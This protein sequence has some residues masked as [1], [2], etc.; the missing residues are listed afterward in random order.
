MSDVRNSPLTGRSAQFSSDEVF[1]YNEKERLG[2]WAATEQV[3]I[4]GF[5]LDKSY[6]SRRL[7]L[8]VADTNRMIALARSKVWI[9]NRL[10]R[11]RILFMTED[12][13]RDYIDSKRDNLGNFQIVTPESLHEEAQALTF[14][15][16]AAHTLANIFRSEDEVGAGVDL[17]MLTLP[18]PGGYAHNIPDKTYPL[19]ILYGCQP[20]E[21]L[22]VLRYLID[23]GWIIEGDNASVVGATYYVTPAGY[24]YSDSV[25]RGESDEAKSAFLICRFNDCLDHIYGAVYSVA[26][27]GKELSCPIYRVKDVEH[28]D[29]IDDRIMAEI[30][31]AT[32]VIVD[33]T[34]ALQNFNV[35]MEAGYALAKGKPIIWTKQDDGT[36]INLPFDIHSQN[37]MSWKR[38]GDEY[39]DFAER[40]RARMKVAIDKA[41][42]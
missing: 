10:G 24:A 26:G 42:D 3:L 15:D 33:L 39:G 17:P 27:N 18:Y 12:G 40:L 6:Q 4:G 14:K 36:D 7:R 23:N 34:D 38:D 11:K 41:S 28:V 22:I 37:L 8:N 35:A 13:L 32:I 25:L 31:A 30:N 9:N 2:V 5:E 1:Y 16:K 20:Q 19:G 29:R 21:G